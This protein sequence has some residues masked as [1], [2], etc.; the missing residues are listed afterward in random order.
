MTTSSRQY[1]R[2]GGLACP[3]CRSK[4]IEAERLEADGPD[5]SAEVTCNACGSTWQDC[6]RLAGYSNLKP[7]ATA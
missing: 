4:D 7:V 1:A 5:A 6:Y 3:T 2:A